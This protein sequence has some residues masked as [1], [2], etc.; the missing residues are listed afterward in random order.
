VADYVVDQL[1]ASGNRLQDVE[2]PGFNL[3]GF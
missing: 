2:V 3:V 1:R